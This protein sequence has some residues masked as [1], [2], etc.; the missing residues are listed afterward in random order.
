MDKTFEWMVL[1]KNRKNTTKVGLALRAMELPK[2]FPCESKLSQKKHFCIS[3][4][5]I[6]THFC[7]KT[8]RFALK[9]LFSNAQ[10][11][12]S[13]A[14]RNGV[15][16]LEMSYVAKQRVMMSGLVWELAHGHRAMTSALMLEEQR[17]WKRGF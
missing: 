4:L 17:H 11:F 12:F 7:G 16:P 6:T 14:K 3:I 5:R 10:P 13:G 9:N 8:P 15:F 2:D 1:N